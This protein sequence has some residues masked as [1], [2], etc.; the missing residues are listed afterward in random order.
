MKYLIAYISALLVFGAIDASWLTVMGR[1]LYRPTLG[2]ILAPDVRLAPAL[3]FYLI[4]PIGIVV[5]AVIPALRCDS[6]PLAFGYAM[7]FGAIAYGTYDLT[8]YATL[9]NWTFQITA[10]D[11]VYGALVSAIAA[12]VSVFAFRVISR[13]LS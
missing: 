5:F 1:I 7:L 6:A 4:Y 10:I 12:A 11:I 8:N 13:W 9:R 3:A 2:D